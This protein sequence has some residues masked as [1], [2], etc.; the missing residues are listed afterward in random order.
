MFK[1][2]MEL[3]YITDITHIFKTVIP[4]PGKMQNVKALLCSPASTPTP[5]HLYVYIPRGEAQEQLL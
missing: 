1:G 4:T 3:G 2:D 5:L